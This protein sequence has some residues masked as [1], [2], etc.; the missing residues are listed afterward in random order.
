MD[1]FV[2]AFAFAIGF[3]A[4]YGGFALLFWLLS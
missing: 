1:V 3:A 4:G 2:H